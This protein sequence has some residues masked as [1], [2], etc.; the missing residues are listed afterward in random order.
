MKTLTK[1]ILIFLGI[2]LMYGIVV[3]YM[4]Y[5]NGDFERKLISNCVPVFNVSFNSS[6]V[7]GVVN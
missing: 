3:V 2:I 6:M 4:A 5:Q 1:I 7:N